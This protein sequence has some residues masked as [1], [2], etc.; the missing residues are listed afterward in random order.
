MRKYFELCMNL[1]LVLF[2]SAAIAVAER[3]ANSS[4]ATQDKNNNMAAEIGLTAEDQGSSRSD[5]KMTA[6]IRSSLVNDDSLSLQA[7]NIKIITRDGKVT[8]RGPVDNQDERERIAALA[9]EIAGAGNVTNDL[10]VDRE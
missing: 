2:V 10:R 9:G 4:A 8:L 5:T 6:D 3:D 7:H 1:A